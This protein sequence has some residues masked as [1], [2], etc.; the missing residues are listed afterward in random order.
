MMQHIH[1][2]NFLHF[3]AFSFASVRFLNGVKLYIFATGNDTEEMDWFEVETPPLL[4][5]LAI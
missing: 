2:I 3:K 5:H 1:T 4:A